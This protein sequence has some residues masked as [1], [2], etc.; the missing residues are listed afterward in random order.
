M[1][2]NFIPF[3]NLDNFLKF[4]KGHGVRSVKKDV[5]DKWESFGL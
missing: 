5:H 2:M 4:S 3:A 1:A